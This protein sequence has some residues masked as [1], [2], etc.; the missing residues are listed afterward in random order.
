[1][2]VPQLA[3]PTCTA[4]LDGD[5]IR[6]ATPF[7]LKDL[8]KSLPGARW[9]AA[10]KTWS[11]PATPAAAGAAVEAL[12]PHGLEPTEPIA[13][14]AQAAVAGIAIK[15]AADGELTPARSRTTPWHHQTQGYHMI[16]EQ[17]AAM[18]AYD[19]GTGKTKCVVDAVCNLDDIRRVLIVC[20]KSVIAVWPREF[21]KHGWT[22]T[23][24]S[25][26]PHA[27]SLRIVALDEGTIAKRTRRADMALKLA[28]ARHEKCVLVI[29]YEAAW[30]GVFGEWA[31]LQDW[32]M[33][34]GDEL[35]RIKAPGGKA[36]RFMEKVG[37]KAGHRVGLTGTPMP[38]SPL[39]VYGQFRFLDTG[40]FGSSFVRFRAR[41]A[42]MG[43][44]Q[45]HE[46]LG[47]Q[48]QDELHAKFY[49]IAHRVKKGDV[50]DLPPTIHQERRV[51]LGDNARRIYHE[52]ERE[53]IADLGTGVI[54]AANALARLLRL[55][56]ITSG[57]GVTETGEQ[58]ALDDAKS[59]E[60]ADILD[61]L[62][63]QEP[64]VCFARFRHDLNCIRTVA[65]KAGRQCMELS[66]RMNE[67]AA[68]QNAKGGE[69]LAVQIQAGGVGI[70][71]T[72]AAYC[73]YFSLGFSLG[74]YSQSLARLDRPGQTRSVT[75]LH[76][77]AA[78]T[79]DEK[80]Y[81]ALQTRAAVVE[82][83]L[84]QIRKSLAAP[85]ALPASRDEA[86]A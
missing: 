61:D 6:L 67:L 36:S 2:T 22:W 30:Q 4:T 75:Y 58:I 28:A 24:P 35:H 50:L 82:S 73:V 77:V 14:L 23:C 79:V 1:M 85:E 29:N 63:I 83:V 25:A 80:V 39:D 81:Q 64:V 17:P 70:D 20:P 8:V 68:W 84:A 10:R 43:G 51:E 33:V 42:V 11:V 45:H 46:V 72:R 59:L 62:D 9:D 54:T 38:H 86:K 32:N 55:Q 27:C 34:V 48:H 49:S 69:V 21:E 53:F 13:A 47:F 31:L 76:L 7:R 37:R 3:A 18:L 57:Y 41:Y 65:E 12:T 15:A 26:D 44:Y 71:L 56:Q 5:R 78:S 52:V 16:V 66:G 19:M 40:I 74:D 60:L